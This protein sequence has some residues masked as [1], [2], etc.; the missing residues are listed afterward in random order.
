MRFFIRLALCPLFALIFSTDARAGA[1]IGLKGVGGRLSYANPESLDATLGVGGLFDLGT[2]AP[3]LG[4]GASLDYWSTTKE[5][6]DFRDIVFGVNLRYLIG[7]SPKFRPYA[8]AGLALHII[9]SEIPVMD[10]I[11][12]DSNTDSK[13]GID[14]FVG[15]TSRVG[16]KIDVLGELMYRSVSDVSQLML[17]GGVVFRLGSAE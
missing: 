12:P 3:H 17:S 4:F 14:L 1:D 5:S 13:I 7:S 10:F 15:V 11:P 8:G 9:H 16:E 6:V 2:F